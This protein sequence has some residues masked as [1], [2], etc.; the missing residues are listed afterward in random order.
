MS[1]ILVSCLKKG[2]GGQRRYSAKENNEDTKRRN[3]NYSC[4]V[5]DPVMFKNIQ[6]H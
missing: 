4:K 1:R 2:H 5:K 6:F 3:I